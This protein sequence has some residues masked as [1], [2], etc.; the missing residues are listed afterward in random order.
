[1]I[2]KIPQTSKVLEFVVKQSMTFKVCKNIFTKVIPQIQGLCKSCLISFSKH[3]LT[4]RRSISAPNSI[5]PLKITDT[6]METIL[7]H[8]N[9]GP[10]FLDLLLSFATGNKESETGPGSM[11]IKHKLD[12][13]YGKS[14]P[15]LQKLHFLTLKIEMQYRLSYVEEVPGNSSHPW[16]I[17]QTGVYHHHVP[18][19]SGSLWIF[20]HPRPNSSLQQRLEACALEWDRSEGSIDDWELTHILTLSSYFGDW[21]WYLKSL[22]A[23]I[24][25]IVCL[26][27]L[28]IPQFG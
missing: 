7:R 14:P 16:A 10:Q 28:H 6:A 2:L 13:S 22:S 27:Y 15:V 26:D 4:I 3:K 21:R 12:G 17:R 11:I 20:L 5:K 23:D 8:H 25:H 18:N 19:G 1:M 24:E 9:V